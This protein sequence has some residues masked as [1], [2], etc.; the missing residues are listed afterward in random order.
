M[1][2]YLKATICLPM[3]VM[4]KMCDPYLGW[5]DP[6]EEE[7]ETHYS[8]LAWKIQWTHK[9]GRLQSVGVSKSQT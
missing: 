3:Q 2:I 9:T 4:Q 7:M 5:E 6:L 1:K 8:I